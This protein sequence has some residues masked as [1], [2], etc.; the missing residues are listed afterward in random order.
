MSS[1]LTSQPCTWFTPEKFV[2]FGSAD[3]RR[4]MAERCLGTKANGERCK[5]NTKDKSGYCHDHID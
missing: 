2:T 3:L 5:R 4:S 1:E